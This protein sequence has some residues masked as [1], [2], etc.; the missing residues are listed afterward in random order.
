MLYVL[1]IFCFLWQR[2]HWLKLDDQHIPA[3]QDLPFLLMFSLM[4][5]YDSEVLNAEFALLK[6]MPVQYFISARVVRNL[7]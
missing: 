3:T 6:H 1:C 5:I 2:G 7:I 4:C